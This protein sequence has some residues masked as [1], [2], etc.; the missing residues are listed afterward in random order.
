MVLVVLVLVVVVLV[1][2]S[3]EE[4]VESVTVVD[5]VLK[6]VVESVTVVVFVVVLGEHDASLGETHNELNGSKTVFP[7]HSSG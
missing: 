1:T 6:L 5:T 7:G 2:G 3:V 4:D